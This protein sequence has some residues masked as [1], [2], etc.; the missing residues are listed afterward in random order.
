M[1][2]LL[3]GRCTRIHHYLAARSQVHKRC[4]CP[5]G[6]HVTHVSVIRGEE[7]PA[8][9][10]NEIKQTPAKGIRM[11]LNDWAS[12][13]R[14]SH[15]CRIPDTA[16]RTRTCEGAFCHRWLQATRFLVM[17]NVFLN[18]PRCRAMCV[19]TVCRTR[20]HVTASTC[21]APDGSV[22]PTVAQGFAKWQPM[23][24]MATTAT[25]TSSQKVRHS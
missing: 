15:S 19:D 12:G 3:L 6:L 18:E 2:S 5:M 14:S 4:R 16:V 11:P 20:H 1:N 10:P 17:I 13:H 23:A 21:S 7:A 9:H 8:P 24:W 22:Q 25:C